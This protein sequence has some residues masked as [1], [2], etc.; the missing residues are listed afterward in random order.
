MT[1]DSSAVRKNLER[2][3]SRGFPRKIIAVAKAD[4]YGCGASFCSKIID[5]ISALGVAT[6]EEGIRLRPFCDKP[7][8]I[9]GYVPI[10]KYPS[11]YTHDLSLTIYSKQVALALA[12]FAEKS[13]ALLK[14]HLKINTGMNRFGV[15]YEDVSEINEIFSLQNLFIEGIYTHFA[16]AD[17]SF[18]QI[19]RERFLGVYRY[20]SQKGKTF[21]FVHTDNTAASLYGTPCG[22][23]VRIGYGMYGFQ[24][25]LT[26]AIRISGRI[27]QIR[28]LERGEGIGYGLTY[29]ATERRD[30]AVV[31]VGYADGY[32]RDMSNVGKVLFHG[33]FL[34]VVGRVCMDCLFVDV[35]G[36]NAREGDYVVLLGA[37]GDKIISPDDLGFGYEVLCR[38][39]ALR[40]EKIYK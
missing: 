40:G 36:K 5:K 23:A 33:E 11:A 3:S 25:Q 20:L 29:V 38:F 2:L 35:T 13:G 28:S 39:G 16:T 15:S 14:A 22:N 26:P 18:Y 6:I 4:F 34:P 7:I 31:S 30:I 8:I 37:D 24:K 17:D 9:F 21:R 10:E 1:V 19:Q 12:A 32:P 27:A